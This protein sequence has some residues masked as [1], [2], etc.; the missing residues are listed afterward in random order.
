MRWERSTIGDTT[1]EGRWGEV[2]V[3]DATTTT[4]VRHCQCPDPVLSEAGRDYSNKHCLA[5]QLAW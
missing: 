3:T 2:P 5:V 4:A 1:R